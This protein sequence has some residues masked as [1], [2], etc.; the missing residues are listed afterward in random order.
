[1]G[2]GC[3]NT[4]SSK[5]KGCLTPTSSNCVSWQGDT[6]TPLDVC[7]GDTITEVINSI[8]TQLTSITDGTDVIITLESLCDSINTELV[9]KEKT[10][11]NVLQALA[12]VLCSVVADVE[13][14][15]TE[16]QPETYSVICLSGGS[17][18]LVSR[19]T[20]IQLLISNVCTLI[21]QVTTLNNTVIDNNFTST[22]NTAVGN[23]IK[24]AITSCGNNG[25]VKLG[26]GDSVT[27]QFTGMVPP[28]CPIPYIGPIGYF[29]NL[30]RGLE[31]Y[32]MCG[33]YILNGMNGTP[34]WMGYTF[35]GATVIPGVT[36]A[37]L[38]AI[39]DGVDYAAN[40]GEKKGEVKHTLVTNEIPLHSHTLT[41][42]G[43]VHSIVGDVIQKPSG[44]GTFNVTLDNY[45]DVNP[46]PYSSTYDNKIIK[47]LTGITATTTGGDLPHENR[48][49]TVYGVWI[50]RKPY[51]PQP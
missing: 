37:P 25:L 40:I 19:Q 15:Q 20:A 3:V 24:T 12:D 17:S 47:S 2:S 44:S 16:L 10:L 41:D 11:T 31:Q 49:P 18:S 50:M 7:V 13:A 29:D 30:G 6:S 23:F 45:T 26:T 1:M 22:I 46:S 5:Q 35:A 8:I 28:F 32:G 39:V 14:I 34:N 21:D 38:D 4:N 43:H 33:W 48:Q 36:S 42:P 51:N 9:G 27:L